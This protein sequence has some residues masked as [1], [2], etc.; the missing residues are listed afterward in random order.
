M[1]NNDS[2]PTIIELWGIVNNK[3][4]KPKNL[5]S[6][7]TTLKGESVKTDKTK[8]VQEEKQKEKA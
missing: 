6:Q 1:K 5:P 4:E 7:L 8:K 2:D 3:R